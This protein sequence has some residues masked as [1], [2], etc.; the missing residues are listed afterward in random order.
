MST[1]Y[2]FTVGQWAVQHNENTDSTYIVSS[3]KY[4]GDDIIAEVNRLP[5]YEEN[6]ALLA[7]A[8][9]MYEALIAAKALLELQAPVSPIGS[10]MMNTEQGRVYLIIKQALASAREVKS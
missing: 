8:K 2:P 1:I 7:S 6:A 9:D 3:D 10:P 5:A 4:E